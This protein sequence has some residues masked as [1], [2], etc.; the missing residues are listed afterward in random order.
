MLLLTETHF[1]IAWSGPLSLKTPNS[2]KAKMNPELKQNLEGILSKES[3]ILT[4]SVFGKKE[5]LYQIERAIDSAKTSIE[6]TEINQDMYLD[7]KKYWAIYSAL[8]DN[9]NCTCF[10]KIAELLLRLGKKAGEK[11]ELLNHEEKNS[12][13]RELKN[14]KQYARSATTLGNLLSKKVKEPQR[15]YYVYESFFKA[16]S[17]LR[18][19]LYLRTNYPRLDEEII[20][21]AFYNK[22]TNDADAAIL[23]NNGTFTASFTV[24]TSFLYSSELEL[25]GGF[26]KIRKEKPSMKLYSALQ[27][28]IYE[29]FREFNSKEIAGAEPFLL[30]KNEQKS[31]EVLK[32]LKRILHPAQSR[33]DEELKSKY[34][35][36]VALSS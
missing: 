26:E 9:G 10:E 12:C 11:A 29:M 21:T 33:Y 27:T 1:S 4:P 19:E 18:Q 13:T 20:S 15:H 36:T 35:E 24:I 30:R 31:S 17:L 2:A 25:T 32:Q 6:L 5:R 14:L 23:T 3:V 7:T 8:K 34:K 28:G 22:L 16:I